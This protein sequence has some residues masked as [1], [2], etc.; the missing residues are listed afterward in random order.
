[1][2]A[3]GLT[4]FSFKGTSRKTKKENIY[5]IF[6]GILGMG[7]GNPLQRPFCYPGT[8]YFNPGVFLGI[9]DSVVICKSGSPVPLS[10]LKFVSNV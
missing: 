5:M 1:M 10:L 2:M 9:L 7:P 4:T 8:V 6:V 3:Y